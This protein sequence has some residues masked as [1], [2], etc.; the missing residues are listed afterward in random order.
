MR[1]QKEVEKEL[2][3]SDKNNNKLKKELCSIKLSKKLQCV[4]DAVQ[5]SEFLSGKIISMPGDELRIV[6][7]EVINSPEFISLFERTLESSTRLAALRRNKAVKA[8]KRKRVSEQPAPSPD[9][10]CVSEII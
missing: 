6:M 3:L 1:E 8:E 2:A 9:T 10:E 7:N 5:R 4:T